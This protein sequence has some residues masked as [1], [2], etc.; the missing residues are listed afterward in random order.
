MV[1]ACVTKKAP[2]VGLGVKSLFCVSI[3]FEK[4]Y[5]KDINA[6]SGIKKLRKF[7]LSSPRSVPSADN[8]EGSKSLPQTLSHKQGRK[9][10]LNHPQALH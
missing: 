4:L 1:I 6:N 8:Y 10:S 9:D 3:V 2:S 5:K 7:P